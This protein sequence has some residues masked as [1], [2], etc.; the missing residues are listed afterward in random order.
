MKR[1]RVKSVVLILLVILNFVL[2]TRIWLYPSIEGIFI[3]QRNNNKQFLYQNASYDISQLFKP[4]KVIINVGKQYKISVLNKS[5]VDQYDVLLD[6]CRELLRQILSNGE[7]AYKRKPFETLDKL[8]NEISLELV[9]NEL[10]NSDTIA[11]LLKLNN[12]VHGEI[13]CIDTVVF[14]PG[15]SKIYLYDKKQEKDSSVFEFQLSFAETDLE[16][17]INQIISQN[18]ELNKTKYIFLN[19]YN[20]AISDSPDGYSFG[21]NVIVPIDTVTLPIMEVK[22]EFVSDGTVTDEIVNFFGNEAS[23]IS[24]S[25]E[26]GGVWRFTDRE[27]A[28]VKID[29]NGT[30]EYIKFRFSGSSINV[31]LQDAMKISSDFVDKH[32]GFPSDAYVSHIDIQ[33]QGGN[34]RYIIKYSYRQEGIPI[35]TSTNTNRHTIEVEIVGSEVKR[36]KRTVSQISERGDSYLT[37]GFSEAADLIKSWNDKRPSNSKLVSIDDMYIAYYESNNALTPV[38]VVDITTK[39][40]QEDKE[41]KKEKLIIRYD[42]YTETGVI[43]DQL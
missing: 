1:E 8:R 25:A 18:S 14:V 37:V 22:K 43:I 39:N 36:Y 15:S 33:N 13:K 21:R 12:N 31:S 16:R 3:M 30:L 38:W 41:S 23:E 5:G 32:M 11:N 19:K 35:I 4:D 27:E 7:I 28:S 26:P 34:I 24:S 2:T 29:V 6:D 9:S 40:P 17:Y 20:E 10:D 42:K